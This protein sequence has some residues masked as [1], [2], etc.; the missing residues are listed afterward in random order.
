MRRRGSTPEYGSEARALLPRAV[1]L[2]RG[3]PRTAV[4]AT[5]LRVY[6]ALRQ[7][8]VPE[9][10]A[11]WLYKIAHNVC[12]S[13]IES[14]AR[15]ARL[16]S[17]QDF[18]LLEDELAAPADRSDELV[19]LADALAAMPPNL[20]QAILLREWQGLS[21]AEIA[22]AMEIS[23]SAV[24]TLIFRARKYLA[25]ALVEP[26][27][28]VAGALN[29]PWLWNLVR[30]FLAGAGVATKIAAG[31]ALLAVAGGGADLGMAVGSTHASRP[32]A[33][34]EACCVAASSCSE[35]IGRQRQPGL[36]VSS[37]PVGGQRI[38]RVVTPA[39]LP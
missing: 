7:G 5:F 32:V 4:Q 19:G 25:K 12:L 37:S 18:S 20:R 26:G 28:R 22:E 35:R 16:E 33:S 31:V 36:A 34:V 9:Y 17:P 21:Y 14:S 27:K 13:R 23:V 10:E 15:R 30:S 6:T 24:E 39:P 2:R 3:G 29:L 38:S 1:A 11:A 8:T